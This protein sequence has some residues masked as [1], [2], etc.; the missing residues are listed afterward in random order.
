MHL[1]FNFNRKWWMDFGKKLI[2]KNKKLGESRLNMVAFKCRLKFV[3]VYEFD[4]AYVNVYMVAA[5]LLHDL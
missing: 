1:G 2:Q 3:N 5:L 4:N